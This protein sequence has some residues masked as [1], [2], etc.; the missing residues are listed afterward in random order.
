MH[1]GKIQPQFK[2]FKIYKDLYRKPD[3][4]KTGW[5]EYFLAAVAISTFEIYGGKFTGYLVLICS[6]SF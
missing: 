5:Q 2:I 3:S 1:K 6:L 4:S